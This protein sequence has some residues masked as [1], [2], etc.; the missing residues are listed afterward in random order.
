MRHQAYL[1]SQFP[2]WAAAPLVRAKLVVAAEGGHAL[3]AGVELVEGAQTA[4]P[5]GHPDED[6]ARPCRGR[7][8]SLHVVPAV[9]SARAG[10][11]GNCRPGPG[12]GVACRTGLTV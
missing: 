5:C 12:G 3:E 1:V 6:H 9:L 4:W 11:R 8:N 2:E 7:C 10:V